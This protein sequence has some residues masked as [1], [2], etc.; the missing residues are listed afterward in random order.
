MECCLTV[1]NSVFAALLFA[2]PRD[3]RQRYGA[4]MAS[5]FSEVSIDT[6]KQRGFC[7]M[8]GLW[9][10]TVYDL[11]LSI[12]TEHASQFTSRLRRDLRAVS[13]AP[14][15]TAAAGALAANLFVAE[16]I[17]FGWTI[18]LHK[19]SRERFLVLAIASLNILVLWV[20][21]LLLSRLFEHK[22][23]RA[24]MDLLAF[25]ERVHAFRHLAATAMVLSLCPTF[26]LVCTSNPFSTASNRFQP[27]PSPYYWILFPALLLMTISAVFLLQPLLTFHGSK[28]SQQG[29]IAGSES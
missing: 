27:L 18:G 19:T 11:L 3:F 17:V 25:T 10:V 16:Q 13:H 23:A 26:W 15:F 12:C 9:C 5:V 1:S 2:F 4:E 21:S 14:A 28:T 8:I 29:R 24:A 22:S 7:G 6:Y 20:G